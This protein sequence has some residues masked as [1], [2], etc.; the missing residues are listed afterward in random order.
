MFPPPHHCLNLVQLE[1][2][3]RRRKPYSLESNME[4]IGC[5]VCEIF[6]VTLKLGSGVTQGRRKWHCSI[7]HIRHYIRLLYNMPLSITVSE[8]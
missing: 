4:W 1:I 8:I 6:D 2:V 7:E 3:R 5:T